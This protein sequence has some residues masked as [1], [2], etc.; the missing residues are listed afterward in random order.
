M[1]AVNVPVGSDFRRTL[2]SEKSP[3]RITR[4][5][6]GK[7]M[8]RHDFAFFHR[9]KEDNSRAENEAQNSVNKLLIDAAEFSKKT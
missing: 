7:Y 5:I 4:M 3:A 9:Q 2:F 6:S 8:N 1:R